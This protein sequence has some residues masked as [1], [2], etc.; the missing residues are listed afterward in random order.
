M[1]VAQGLFCRINLPKFVKIL[2]KFAKCTNILQKY[3]DFTRIRKNSQ[4]F[5]YLTKICENLQKFA[6]ILPKFTSSFLAYQGL[7]I[8]RREETLK[9][10]QK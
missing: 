5:A 10:A 8:C 9:N 7:Y 4:K 1:L 6:K 2:Q 3:A